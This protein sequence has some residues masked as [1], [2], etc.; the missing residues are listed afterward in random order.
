MSQQRQ[1]PAIIAQFL[2]Q[3]LSNRRSSNST[4][5]SSATQSL[6]FSSY[7]TLQQRLLSVRRKRY[8]VA[9]FLLV[10][11]WLYKLV[12]NKLQQTKAYRAHRQRHASFTKHL[13]KAE[14][15]SKKKVHINCIIYVL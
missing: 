3:T 5:T 12:R 8:L 1:L 13:I 11:P 2:H 9:L 15:D 6:S 7:A 4:A 14:T 10:T